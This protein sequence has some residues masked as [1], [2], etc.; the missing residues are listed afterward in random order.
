MT[1]LD[2]LRRLAEE[3]KSARA[4][5]TAALEERA[6]SLAQAHLSSWIEAIEQGVRQ[7]ATFM[8]FRHLDHTESS[9]LGFRPN[10]KVFN[11]RKADRN[12]APQ[13]DLT[14]L[15]SALVDEQGFS[16]HGIRVYTDELNRHLSGI[17]AIE[18]RIEKAS[19]WAIEN[20]DENSS[21]YEEFFHVDL[22][23]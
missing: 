8:R 19:D 21:A 11:W 23:S 22:R 2:R 1:D 15:F 20:D 14:E 5:E 9:F 4:K 10:R 6:V 17:C 7:R 16:S 18:W 3:A 12:S 13:I